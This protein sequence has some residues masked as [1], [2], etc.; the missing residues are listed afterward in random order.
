VVAGARS[1]TARHVGFLR[2]AG[3]R[4]LWIAALL[5]FAAAAGYRYA[6][7]HPRPRGDTWYGYAT[8]LAGAVLILWL[9]A[10][11]VRKRVITSG[12]WSLKGWLSAHVYLGLALVVVATVH[13]GFEF[14][15]NVHTLAFVLMLTVVASGALGAAAYATLPR[16]LS[17]NRHE[18]TQVQMLERLRA[19]DGRLDEAAQSL[20]EGAAR[21]VRLSLEQTRISGGLVERLSGLRPG[22]GNRRAI[23]GLAGLRRRLT[24]ASPQLDQIAT[25]LDL[26]EAALGQARRHIR[27]RSLL[28]AWLFVHVPATFALLA[29]LTAHIVSVFFYW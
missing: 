10:L 11:G 8:G 6:E 19:L 21:I 5:S 23:V 3:F 24:D 1:E 25:L 2:H 7:V 17:E 13:T 16:R 14:G 27:L 29:A 18:L 28:D 12:H 20:D 15:W 22:C 9:A 26:K 4:W